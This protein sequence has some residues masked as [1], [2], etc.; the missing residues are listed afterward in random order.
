MRMLEING[1]IQIQ[2]SYVLLGDTFTE[3]TLQVLSTKL[4]TYINQ[5]QFSST[6]YNIEFSAM[7]KDLNLQ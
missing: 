4:H 1:I 3:Y 7:V 5:D 6:V 2:N